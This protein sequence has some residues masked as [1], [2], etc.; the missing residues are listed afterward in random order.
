MMRQACSRNTIRIFTPSD[1]VLGFAVFVGIVCEITESVG[2]EVE[3]I[4]G[5]IDCCLLGAT[6]GM[7]VGMELSTFVGRVEG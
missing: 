1:E 3:T 2:M 5:R 7:S 6:V 4:E